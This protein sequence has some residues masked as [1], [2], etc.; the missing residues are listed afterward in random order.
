[1]QVENRTTGWMVNGALMEVPE[2]W[3]WE[4]FPMMC[5][6]RVHSCLGPKNESATQRRSP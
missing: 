3:T 4:R 2:A 1:M 5:S 6:G